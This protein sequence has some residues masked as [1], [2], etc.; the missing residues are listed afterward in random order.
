M[1]LQYVE[2]EASEEIMNIIME[3]IKTNEDSKLDFGQ[4]KGVAHLTFPA[5]EDLISLSDGRNITSNDVNP[6]LYA[7]SKESFHSVIHITKKFPKI[8]RQALFSGEKYQYQGQNFENL[9]L[10]FLLQ[11]KN[12]DILNFLLKKED[13]ILS[14]SDLQSFITVAL[15]EEFDKGIRTILGTSLANFAFQQLGYEDQ[16]S[17]IETALVNVSRPRL[18][19]LLK[20]PYCRFVFMELLRKSDAM[21]DCIYVATESLSNLTSEDFFWMLHEGSGDELRSSIESFASKNQNLKETVQKI[22]DRIQNEILQA[23]HPNQD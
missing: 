19:T 14:G 10:P 11:V 2:Q 21:Y 12:T 6:L 15:G 1:L 9:A 20:K 22:F 13:F 5:T 8:L 3:A 18:T 23:A 4:L 7:I 16:T 17:L